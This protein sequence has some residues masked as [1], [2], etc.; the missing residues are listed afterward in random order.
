MCALC[1]DARIE[2]KAGHHKAVGQPTEAALL[3]LAEKLG[4]AGEAAQKGI[5]ALRLADP[6]AH[7]TGACQHHAAK[8]R[9]LATLEFDRDRKVCGAAGL[10]SGGRVSGKVAA[11]LPSM[12][13]L[14][15]GLHLP[16]AYEPVHLYCFP[17][18]QLQSMSVICTPAS[19][20]GVTTSAA[21]GATPRRSG[22][23]ASLLSRTSSEGGSSGGNVLFVKGAAECV[24]QRC[25][26]VML[27]DGSIVPMSAAARTE[28]QE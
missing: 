9:K 22:R 7:P 4:V 18:L 20:A 21:V 23:L 17:L 24:L 12:P 8:W 14:L 10:G 11:A 15:M 6:E 3:V 5:R 28:L 1:N 2:F 27:A 25:T 13:R 16:V 26:R 19:G